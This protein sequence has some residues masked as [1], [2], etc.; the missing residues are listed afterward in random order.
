MTALSEINCI[1]PACA[2]GR[3]K[4]HC[5]AHESPTRSAGFD[6]ENGL[7]LFASTAPPTIS[8]AYFSEDS[9]PTK[10]KYDARAA[11]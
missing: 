8:A 6:A 3:A 2:L 5:F 4:L 7:Y 10:L 11:I 9:P 1:L